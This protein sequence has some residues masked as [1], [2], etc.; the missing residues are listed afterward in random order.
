MS[1]SMR[2]SLLLSKALPCLPPRMLLQI[3]QSVILLQL[4]LTVL[5]LTILLLTILLLIVLLGL[6]C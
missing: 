5:L 3:E 1:H 6:Y 2:W 4:M